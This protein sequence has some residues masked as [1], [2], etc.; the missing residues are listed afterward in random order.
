[1]CQCW[2]VQVLLLMRFEFLDALS[3]RLLSPDHLRL[4][5]AKINGSQININWRDTVVNKLCSGCSLLFGLCIKDRKPQTGRR[6][7]TVA[8]Q[9]NHELGEETDGTIGIL[10]D[11][12]G[13]KTIF[14]HLQKCSG[15]TETGHLWLKQ[16][17]TLKSTLC[18]EISHP[19]INIF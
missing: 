14:D 8:F 18:Q 4:L 5:L 2:T 13:L 6:K 11:R 9:G 10:E 7:E 16:R 1:M 15:E 19:S 17:E 12:F 3:G